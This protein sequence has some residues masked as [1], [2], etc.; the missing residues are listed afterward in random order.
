[1]NRRKS[2]DKFSGGTCKFVVVE[3]MGQQDAEQLNNAGEEKICFGGQH[4]GG[5]TVGDAESVF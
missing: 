5:F 2:S 1:M 3:F 4:V